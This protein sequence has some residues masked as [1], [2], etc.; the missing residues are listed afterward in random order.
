MLFDV[1]RDVSVTLWTVRLITR[2]SDG[3]V[4]RFFDKELVDHNSQVKATDGWYITHRERRLPGGLPGK[5][6]T[7]GI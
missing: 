1:Y 4:Y 3:H 5:S 7:P 6:G 2:T